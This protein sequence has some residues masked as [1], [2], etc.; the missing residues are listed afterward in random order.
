MRCG[1]RAGRRTA[2][3]A[4][5]RPRRARPHRRQALRQRLRDRVAVRG[6]PDAGGVDAGAAGVLERSTRPS[7]RGSAPSRRRVGAE[8]H[9]AVAGPVQLDARVA[10]SRRRRRPRRRT[11]CRARSAAGSRRAPAWSAGSSERLGRRAAARNAWMM[12]YGVQGSALPGFSTSAVFSAIAG[13][14]SECTPGELL[15]STTPSVCA[16]RHEADSAGPAVAHAAVEHAQVEAAGEAG[17]HLPAC[18][19]HAADLL[20]VAADHHVRQA[21]G[22][23]GLADVVVGRLRLVAERQRVRRR[24]VAPRARTASSS[25]A[26]ASSRAAAPASPPGL[27]G[28]GRGA[29]RPAFAWLTSATA[30]RVR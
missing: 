4:P 21:G 6:R 3:A 5:P 2:R 29:T 7:R 18:R 11:P 22:G 14:H 1:D 12:R 17:E 19:E 26:G 28:A 27:P 25:S 20:H 8:Q 24:S 13:T 16:A 9:L 15:G 23:R 10:A 30:S